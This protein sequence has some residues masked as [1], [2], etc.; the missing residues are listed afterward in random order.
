[1]A[2]VTSSYRIKV[3]VDHTKKYVQKEMCVKSKHKPYNYAL[4]YRKSV[5]NTVLFKIVSIF[6]DGFPSLFSLLKFTL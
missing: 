6:D 5:Y 2:R 3:V 1:M 4:V